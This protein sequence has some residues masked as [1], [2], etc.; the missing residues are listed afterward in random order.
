LSYTRF[1]DQRARGKISQLRNE[2]ADA[3]RAVTGE[4]FEIFQDT[5]GIGLGGHWPGKLHRMLDDARF[6]IPILTPSY[7]KSLACRDE[8][9]KFL[10]AEKEKGRRDLILP[11]YYLDC[12]VVEQPEQR[13]GDPLATAIHERQRYDWR[14][15]R[16]HTFSTRKMAIEVERKARAIR[17]ARQRAAAPMA[18]ARQGPEVVPERAGGTSGSGSAVLTAPAPLGPELSPGTVFRDKD[19]PWCPELVV[20]PPGAFVGAREAAAPGSDRL[21]AG[22][23][24]V[25]GDVRRI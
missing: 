22:R 12:E 1:D 5:D 13:F 4:P 8:L 20:I 15:L 6:F 14:E 19:A 3:V 18:R 25:P 7:F 9:D 11:I 17:D 23:Q 16:H 21:S 24:P 10:R 2:L